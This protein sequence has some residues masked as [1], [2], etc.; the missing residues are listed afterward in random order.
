M[1]TALRIMRE[2]DSV[3]ESAAV[4]GYPCLQLNMS[5]EGFVGGSVGIRELDEYVGI[6]R[7]MKTNLWVHASIILIISQVPNA[8]GFIDI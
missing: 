1:Y 7:G 2:L 5:I 4:L 6:L 8:V 3:I